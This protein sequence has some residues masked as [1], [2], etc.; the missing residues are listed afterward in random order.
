MPAT[1]IPILPS[2]DFDV[3]EAFYGR[4][5]FAERGRWPGDYL[6]LVHPLGIEVHF[7]LNEELW[8]PK[9]AAGCYVRFDTAAEVSHLHAAWTQAAAGDGI[10]SVVE[11][12]YG[13]LEF[14]VLDPHNNQIRFG[15]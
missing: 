11:T 2:A 4:L 14:A 7:W 5:G 10:R 15:G 1:T 9:H 3:T 12:D 8:E 13:L 6:I